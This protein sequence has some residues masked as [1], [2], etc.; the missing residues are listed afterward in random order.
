MGEES[1]TDAPEVPF[2]LTVTFDRLACAA[3]SAE[4]DANQCHEAD[5]RG[6]AAGLAFGDE[7]V[8]EVPHVCAPGAVLLCADEPPIIE[9]GDEVIDEHG[10]MIA[11]GASDDANASDEEPNGGLHDGAK[12]GNTGHNSPADKTH[13]PAHGPQTNGGESGNK[14]EDRSAGTGRKGD[15]RRGNEAEHGEEGG[16]AGFPKH[17]E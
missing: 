16:F 10:A 5:E 8:A 3:Q 7:L 2:L 14:G 15:D 6:E 17:E 4:G 1:A 11:G 13:V 9:A 12:G